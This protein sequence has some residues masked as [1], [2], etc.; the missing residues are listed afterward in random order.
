MIE[1]LY[2]VER[3]T[4]IVANSNGGHIEISADASFPTGISAPL[5]RAQG[6]LAVTS[7]SGILQ[8]G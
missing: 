3:A 7:R 6:A 1:S 8:K 5:A 2:E 4:I